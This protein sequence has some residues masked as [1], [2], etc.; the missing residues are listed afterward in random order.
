MNLGEKQPQAVEPAPGRP[1]PVL[2]VGGRKIPGLGLLPVGKDQVRGPAMV[3]QSL[4]VGVDRYPQGFL[5]AAADAIIL[6]LL[7]GGPDAPFVPGSQ[8]L[9]TEALMHPPRA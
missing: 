9:L 3:A 1:D 5:R 6:V 2:Q 8:H 7:A 4:Q